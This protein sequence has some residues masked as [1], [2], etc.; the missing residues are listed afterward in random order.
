MRVALT[1]RAR[2]ELINRGII[3]LRLP[4]NGSM[5]YHRFDRAFSTWIVRAT[6]QP[7]YHKSVITLLLRSS[8]RASSGRKQI[9]RL[10]DSLIRLFIKHFTHDFCRIFPLLHILLIDISA[11][12]NF[13]ERSFEQSN[14]IFSSVH[15]FVY[16]YSEM[17]L[18]SNSIDEA[19]VE[20]RSF[21][22][23]ANLVSRVECERTESP[24]RNFSL[25]PL[26]L[27]SGN[28]C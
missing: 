3:S 1:Y 8:L 22:C 2:I 21:D 6:C 25:S 13:A 5:I 12:I 26:S 18:G 14:R 27:C 9:L 19:K 7:A 28:V 20:M 23:E 4:D 15:S 16:L 24:K 11:M 10:C 17:N